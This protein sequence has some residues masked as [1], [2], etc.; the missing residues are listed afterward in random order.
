[1]CSFAGDGKD[2]DI[3]HNQ[4]SG[5]LTIFL[6][7]LVFSCRSKDADWPTL[8]FGYFQLKA[9]KEWKKIDGKGADTYLGGL[10]NGNDT[11]W[12]LYGRYFS[13]PDENESTKHLYGQD[14]I[15]GYSA[16]VVLPKK[17]ASEEKQSNQQYDF[18][19]CYKTKQRIYNK[20]K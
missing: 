20:K 5:R 15:N 18:T 1:M 13:G 2:A 19:A 9:P 8:D 16:V 7:I 6:I 10:T 14:T 4:M 12:F 11:L 3:V 17:E